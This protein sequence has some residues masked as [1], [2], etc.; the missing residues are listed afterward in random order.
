MNRKFVSDS[1]AIL[2]G[3]SGFKFNRKITLTE[4]ID[5]VRFNTINILKIYKIRGRKVYSDDVIRPI[6]Y[7]RLRIP[8][9]RKI[10]EILR[11]AESSLK[12]SHHSSSSSSNTESTQIT[13]LFISYNYK[14]F[15]SPLS[16][17]Y[18]IIYC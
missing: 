6:K 9:S 7:G 1:G 2:N 16:L 15:S 3:A 11:F 5:R 13:V 4:K 10:Y 8:S 12:E 14:V 17:P 18:I